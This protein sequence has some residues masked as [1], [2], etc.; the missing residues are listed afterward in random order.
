VAKNAQVIE[1][2][3][4]QYDAITG[5][6]IVSV[7]KLAEK[8]VKPYQTIDGFVRVP[9]Y[10]FSASKDSP[11]DNSSAKKGS[12]AQ[13][14]HQG[15]Q[16]SRT[17]MRNL[18]RR[19]PGHK[20][21]HPE[22]PKVNRSTAAVNTSRLTRANSVAKDERVSR[23]GIFNTTK[24]VEK[25]PVP[26]THSLKRQPA[27]ATVASSAVHTMPSMVTSASH[28]QLERLLDLALTNAKAHKLALQNRQ[29]AYSGWRRVKRVPSWAAVSAAVLVVLVTTGLFAWQS[30]PQLAV[31]VA[32]IGSDVNASVPSYSPSG[33]SF[34]GP[35]QF[36]DNTVTMNFR[37]NADPSRSY[38]VVQKRTDWDSA[39]L[40]SNYL[41]P[42]K[43]P[44]QTSAVKGS[45]VY[46][47]GEGSDATWINNGTWYTIK[48]QANLTSDQ[49]IKIAESL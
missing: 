23:F 22:P 24:P 41:E 39:S 48:D 34:E 9:A 42:A 25:K 2:N 18:V 27:K 35:L 11:G 28:H 49:L 30:M 43:Q 26:K 3:G 46:F 29:G 5:Q 37:S 45:T 4:H 36:N 8:A 17:L 20:N 16:R 14:V 10:H 38:A 1:I 7:K 44:Y 6:L 12:P 31:R 19:P 15:A 33:F 13:H 32:S 21:P 47:Y 40:V